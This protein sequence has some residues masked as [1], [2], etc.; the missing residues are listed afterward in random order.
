MEYEAKISEAKKVYEAKIANEAKIASEAKI[1]FASE[2][3]IVS[4]GKN[5]IE[6]RNVSEAEK[7]SVA[8][9]I[10][11]GSHCYGG[12]TIQSNIN[13]IVLVP[14]KNYWTTQFKNDFFG[15]YNCVNKKCVDRESEK[16]VK[17]YSLF[18]ILCEV[19]I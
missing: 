5:V 8:H 19:K 12:A 16:V 7:V 15:E 17:D 6:A 11:G 3:E 14:Y 2:A 1:D 18:C 10:L 9:F 4:K 13:G